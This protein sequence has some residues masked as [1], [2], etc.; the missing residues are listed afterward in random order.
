[1]APGITKLAVPRGRGKKEK[2]AHP[3]SSCC[4]PVHYVIRSPACWAGRHGFE[5]DAVAPPP[6]AHAWQAG[7]SLGPS[8]ELRWHEMRYE[9]RGRLGL[10]WY[11]EG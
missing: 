2:Q 4:L 9:T 5:M 10:G 3:Y 11:L 7:D 1:M 8:A 6:G